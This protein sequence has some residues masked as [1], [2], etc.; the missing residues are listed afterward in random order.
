MKID[1]NKMAEYCKKRGWSFSLSFNPVR[2]KETEMSLVLYDHKDLP[3][4]VF[5]CSYIGTDRTQGII[6]TLDITR[7]E[8]K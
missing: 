5:S 6:E 8:E 3:T 7:K 4:G 1:Y 2:A